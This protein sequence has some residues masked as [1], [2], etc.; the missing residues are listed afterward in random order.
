MNPDY[1][2]D[3]TAS[4]S[5]HFMQSGVRCP[6]CDSEGWPALV[7]GAYS[8]VCGSVWGQGLEPRQTDACQI[9]CGLRFEVAILQMTAVSA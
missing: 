8:A 9:I 5:H 6:L 3:S 4:V 7:V 1:R 2:N